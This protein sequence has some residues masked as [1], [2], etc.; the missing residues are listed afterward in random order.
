MSLQQANRHFELVERVVGHLTARSLPLVV[1]VVSLRSD[2]PHIFEAVPILF[3][4]IV[5]LLVAYFC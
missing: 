2:T 4:S 5:S 1:D 3:V